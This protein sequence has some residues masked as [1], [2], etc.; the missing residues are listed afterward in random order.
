MRSLSSLTNLTLIADTVAALALPPPA[1]GDVT[2]WNRTD[3][4]NGTSPPEFDLEVWAEQTSNLTNAVLYGATTHPKVIAD[5]TITSVANG[6]NEYTKVA[7]GL[8]T[9]DGPTFFTSSGTFPA[10]SDGVT[11][12]YI[13][14]T[15]ADTF[16]IALTLLGALAGTFV[17]L[18]T[19]GSGVI[20][21][22]DSADTQRVY[23]ET[24]DGLLGIDHDGAIA[25]TSS[26]GYRKRIPHSPRVFA[27][28]LVAT[29]SAGNVSAGV[30]PIRSL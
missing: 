24:H 5:I 20:K 19:D 9:G 30:C 13:I 4:Q 16:K 15:G 23:W 7:H 8:Q 1:F 2:S 18:T 27:Y 17:D 21:L 10:G 25:L 14:K 28:A 11:P 26:V 12:Y 6:A 22:V 29:I 3:T